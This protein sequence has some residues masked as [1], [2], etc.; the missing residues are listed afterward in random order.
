M[1]LSQ[2]VSLLSLEDDEEIEDIISDNYDRSQRDLL[3]IAVDVGFLFVAD[4]YQLGATIDNL[5]Y[6]EF[7]YSDFRENCFRLT[8]A[9]LQNCTAEVGFVQTGAVTQSA[10]YVPRTQVTV[11]GAYYLKSPSAVVGGSLDLNKQ[12]DAVGG[13]NQDLSLYFTVDPTFTLIPSLR[14][15]YHKNLAGEKLSSIG[16]GTTLFH[17]FNLDMQVGLDKVSNDGEEVARN[18]AIAFS[19]EQRL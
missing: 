9:E 19:F 1:S 8:G 3:D 13:E 4:R 10:R 5:L 16:L 17:S 15:S 12:R 18:F 14:F 2:S 7:Q 6:L 11:E